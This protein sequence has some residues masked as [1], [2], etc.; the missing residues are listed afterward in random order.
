MTAAN[1]EGAVLTVTGD[2]RTR[3]NYLVY[4]I[5]ALGAAGVAS[6]VYLVVVAPPASL[7]E[8][9]GG[10]IGVAAILAG[11]LA[12]DRIPRT[13]TIKTDSV[14]FDYLLG[15]VSVEWKD[16][17]APVYSRHGFLDFTAVPGTRGVWGGITVT[18]KQAGAI[19]SHSS[20]PRFDLPPNV[21]EELG[22][23]G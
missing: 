19:L 13:V 11:L 17:R 16:L 10:F 5:F 15:H 3:F 18:T 2:R 22:G 8:L 9:G 1:L 21:V 6:T 14:E 4:A 7:L 20:C 23:H 12:L